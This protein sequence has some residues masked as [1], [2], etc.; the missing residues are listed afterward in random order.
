MNRPNQ[1]WKQRFMCN[2]CGKDFNRYVGRNTFEVACPR[3]HSTDT[4]LVVYPHET[5]SHVEAHGL[6][7][8]GLTKDDLQF[9]F[10][11]GGK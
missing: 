1:K 8:F 2:E 6:L 9:A 11:R 5:K 7:T 10:D 4:E 3:C